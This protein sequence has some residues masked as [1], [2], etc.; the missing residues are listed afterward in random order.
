MDIDGNK[1]KEIR[2]KH[3]I[4]LRQLGSELNISYTTLSRIENGEF[5][6]YNLETLKRIAMYFNVKLTD[7]QRESENNLQSIVQ[8]SYNIKKIIN[9]KLYDIRKFE[10]NSTIESNHS[11]SYI[12]LD[13]PYFENITDYLNN[14]STLIYKPLCINSNKKG[15][16]I[17]IK[18]QVPSLNDSSVCLLI[19]LINII[20]SG[21]IAL[22]MINQQTLLKKIYYKNDLYFLVDP[23]QSSDP[24]MLS[25][26]D[27]VILGTLTAI[28]FDV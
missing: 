11:S 13:I 26:K 27:F 19:K 9:N 20:K 22:I 5:K 23:F 28:H 3:G 1:I 6:N 2:K 8:N 16:Y 12:N 7:F 18:Y 15:D 10:K 4:T 21:D 14:N 25:S 17:Y 24:M